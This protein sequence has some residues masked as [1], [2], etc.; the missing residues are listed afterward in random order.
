[1]TVCGKNMN[2]FVTSGVTS[3]KE[4][5]SCKKLATSNTRLDETCCHIWSK[6]ISFSCTIVCINVSYP[7]MIKLDPV[8]RFT[9]LVSKVV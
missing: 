5:K 2:Y 8:N 3:S 6:V 9:L 7:I 4:T 1:M